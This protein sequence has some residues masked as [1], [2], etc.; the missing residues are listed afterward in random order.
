M[1]PA[2]GALN[3][4]TSTDEF[5][6]RVG[7]G[8]PTSTL[9]SFEIFTQSTGGTVTLPARIYTPSGSRPSAT[10]IATSTI[11]IGPNAGFYTAT[12]NPPVSVPNSFYIGFDNT[13]QTTLLSDLNTGQINLGYQRTGNGTWSFAIMRPSWRVQCTNLPLFPVPVAS[14]D[15]LPILGTSYTVSYTHLT[16]PTIE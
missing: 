12:F 2:G 1:N 14:A 4:T 11:T 13:A 16:L 3:Q 7:V 10:P 9:T 6:Y 5:V 8:A 15:A